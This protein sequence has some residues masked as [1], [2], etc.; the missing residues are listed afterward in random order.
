MTI[1][2]YSWQDDPSPRQ[3]GWAVADQAASNTFKMAHPLAPSNLR[4]DLM[5]LTR[6]K[7]KKAII[8]VDLLAVSCQTFNL[9]P[10]LIVSA[11][12]GAITIARGDCKGHHHRNL[13]KQRLSAASSRLVT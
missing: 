8:L 3:F 12:D 9:G 6:A 11:L 4:P 2:L 1:L 5:T 13:Q 7:Q 10:L